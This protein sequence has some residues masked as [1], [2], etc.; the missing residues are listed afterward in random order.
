MASEKIKLHV[1]R[2]LKIISIPLYLLVDIVIW[3]TALFFIYKEMPPIYGLKIVFSVIS[4][5]FLF[6]YLKIWKIN[7]D[8]RLASR[9]LLIFFV[10]S[11]V[12]SVIEIVAYSIINKI[13]I[14][15]MTLALFNAT[16]NAV[17]LSS[18]FMLLFK[19]MSKDFELDENISTFYIPLIAKLGL[20]VYL[21]FSTI[22]L[23][24]L[25]N[26]VS[27]QEDVYLKNYSNSILNEILA[28]SDNIKGIDDNIKSDMMTYS[29]SV[30]NIYSNKSVISKDDIQ[31]Y[32]VNRIG[33]INNTLK[34]KYNT[35]SININQEYLD[36]DLPYSVTI[37]KDPTT[38]R[39]SSRASDALAIHNFLENEIRDN[40]VTL[41]INVY[42]RNNIYISAYTPL[43]LFGKDI[44]YLISETGMESINNIIKNNYTLS[45]W[46]YI[47]YSTEK[48]EIILSYDSRYIAE[49]SSSILSS[50]P[51]LVQNI[52]NFEKSFGAN[53]TFE[54]LY[55]IN[56]GGK[57][58]IAI[59]SYIKELKVIG[60]YYK[61]IN[62][63]IKD[64]NM[65]LTVFNY[66]FISI[67]ILFFGVYLIILKILL[68]SINKA[69]KSTKMLLGGNG[70]LRKRISSKN[71]DEIG[72]LIYNFNLFLSSLDNLIGDL[73]VESYKVFE[74][75]K[76]I[77]KIIDENTNRIN[78]QSSSI[79]ESV[80]SVNNIITS[81]QNVTS[82]TDQQ[83]HAFSSASIAV[84]EL[85][86]TIYKINDNMERQSSA[87]E[88]T[89]ASIEEMI[90]NIT[91][92]ARSVNK[93]DSF[94]KKLLVDA[95]DGGDT[96]DEVI[97]A[98]RGIEESSDQIKEIVNVIQGIAEQTNLLAMNAAIEAA[99]AGEQGRG[100]SV[101]ADEIRSLA[102]HTADNTKSITNIIKAITKRIEETVEL[103][104][105]SGKSL[106]NILDMSENTARVVSEINTANS[107]LEVG[108]RDI[109]ETIRH[110]N[111]ITT[112]VKDSVKEQMNSG[113]VV[114][115]QITLLDQITREV[116][117]IIEANSSGAKEVMHAMS[118]LNE[119][120]VKTVEGNKE[121][122]TATNKLNEIFVKF[123]ELMGKFITNADDIEEDKNENANKNPENYTVDERMDMELRSLE[124]EFK[125]DNDEF[126]KDDDVL[127]MLK[128]D[129]K[130]PEMFNM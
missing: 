53:N 118:F 125:N 120:S 47:Y 23:A 67:F 36:T 124:E 44:G 69:N 68:S 8:I 65:N 32:I 129:F 41:N 98:V 121:F 122:Y 101:V 3:N 117:D 100:F 54:I 55:P 51:E 50:S 57:K 119:L 104:S 27:V 115:S 4:F 92:V 90:S 71:N 10:I 111:N 28:V 96:V 102:E 80:A 103:A 116:S 61:D 76:V 94:S 110:L 40:L 18:V 19:I 11:L 81:I 113:D 30:L 88:Q 49:S 5:I 97:E 21:F 75:I 89:S 84:E 130:N 109:L 79:T 93:A 2:K 35:I 128:E 64:S 37:S 13:F 72:V 66:I 38:D 52:E 114:D 127:E 45:K 73:K 91:S 95:H 24:F 9:V 107:E 46:D 20:I 58:S 12:G 123:H 17:L 105:N 112:G 77:E 70:D 6:K 1:I 48:R 82:S 16:I 60:L 63:L 74:E 99:H 25:M 83:K 31:N 39:Y 59:I 33:Y 85:L 34:N 126:K 43:K 108:G 26:Y 56:I 42:D 15:T 29:E 7:S 14:H 87:V 22:I 62:T 86:Q 78:D 106:D